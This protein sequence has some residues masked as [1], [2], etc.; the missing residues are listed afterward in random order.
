MNKRQAINVDGAAAPVGPYSH[1]VKAGGMLFVSGQIPVE[2]L[3][4]EQVSGGIEAET[5]RVMENIKLVVEG[6]GAKMSDAVKL[7]CYLAEMS[8]FQ[9]FNRVYG[10]YFPEAPPARACI[11]AAQLPLGVK[12]EVDAIVAL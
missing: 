4:G 6:A 5:R 8:D 12:V 3:S 10:E 2:P 1:C 9:A 11:Q 7:T